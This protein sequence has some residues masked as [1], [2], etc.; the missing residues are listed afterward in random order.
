MTSGFLSSFNGQSLKNVEIYSPSV[1][2]SHGQ[3]YVAFSRVTSKDGLKMFISNE[4][5]QDT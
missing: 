3:V 2:F 5:G 4:E 1:V